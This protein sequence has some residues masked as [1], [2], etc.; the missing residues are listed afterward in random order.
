[1]NYFKNV[2]VIC[3]RKTHNPKCCSR[4]C[5]KKEANRINLIKYHRKREEFLANNPSYILNGKV[6]SKKNIGGYVL[7]KDLTIRI[8]L[9][10]AGKRGKIFPLDDDDCRHDVNGLDYTR[11]NVGRQIQKNSREYEK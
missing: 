2:C 3:G 7:K 11:L 10:V 6:R 9:T 8:D 5:Q 1:M 4:E